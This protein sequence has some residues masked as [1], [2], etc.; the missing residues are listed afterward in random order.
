MDKPFVIGKLLQ[1]G[2]TNFEKCILLNM[3]DKCIK[4][5]RMREK[6]N[7]HCMLLLLFAALTG[8]VTILQKLHGEPAPN[9]EFRIYGI[10]ITY[11]TVP[12][13]IAQC[14]GHTDVRDWLLF[15]IGVDQENGYVMWQGLQLQQLEIAWLRKV[16]W[17]KNLRLCR[18]RLKALPSEMDTYLKQVYTYWHTRYQ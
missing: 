17:V 14:S 6:P 8:N 12:L 10:S 4:R 5:A 3:I 16:S 11:I 7:A 13:Q 9:K 2:T 15:M 1:T 18:N